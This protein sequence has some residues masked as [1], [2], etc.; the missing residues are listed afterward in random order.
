MYG[1]ARECTHWLCEGCFTISN[2]CP[3]C[4][5]SLEMDLQ[6]MLQ[7]N[8]LHY[9]SAGSSTTPAEGGLQ[10][11]EQL[12]NTFICTVCHKHQDRQGEEAVGEEE[13][14]VKQKAK[15][16]GREAKEAWRKEKDQNG[17]K[18]DGK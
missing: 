6:V 18:G 10:P 7:Q 11:G 9:L 3:Q 12:Q 8:P 15:V 4:G 16:Q 5:A 1:K 17:G 13:G 14:G 2:I